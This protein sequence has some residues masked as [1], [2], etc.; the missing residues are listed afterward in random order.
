M[1]VEEA[2]GRV[3][4]G[5]ERVEVTDRRGGGVI[6]YYRKA[7]G[8]LYVCDRQGERPIMTL[9]RRMMKGSKNPGAN[10]C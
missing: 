1:D 8:L 10:R 9:D 2:V 5:E 7:D 6:A 3:L 4:D